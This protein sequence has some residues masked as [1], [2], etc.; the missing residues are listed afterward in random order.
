LVV[1][2]A[3]GWR[4]CRFFCSEDLEEHVII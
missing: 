2:N 4:C 1:L 3:V